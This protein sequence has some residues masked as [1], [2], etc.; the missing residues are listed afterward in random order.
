MRGHFRRN[1]YKLYLEKL[2]EDKGVNKVNEYKIFIG[3]YGE[4]D[5]KEPASAF[6]VIESN[7]RDFITLVIDSCC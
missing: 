7:L 1:C 4:A 6:I 3:K 2:Q 5:N